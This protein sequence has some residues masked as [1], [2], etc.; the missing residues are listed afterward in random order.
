MLRV[1]WCNGL[2]PE[3]YQYMCVQEIRDF[4]TLVHKCRM[5]DDAGKAKTNHYKAVHDKKGKGHG[6]GKP[7]NKD[8]GKKREVG[9]GSKSSLADVRCF[10][11]G[12]FGH[13]SNDCKKDESCFKCGQAG[14]KSFECKKEVTCYNCGEKGHISAKCTKP[15]KAAGKVFALNAEEV[16]QPDNLIRGMCFINSTPLIA[17]IDTGATHSFISAS[18]VERLNLVVTSLLRGMVI[19]TPAS[20]S[21]TTSLVCARCPVNF[22]N[23]D[24]ELD[25]VCLPLK[26]MDVIFGMD[27]MLTFGVSI[28]CL[29]KSITFSKPVDELGGKF[30]T[31]EQVKKSLDS[32]AC[33]FMM[34]ASLKESSEKEVGDLPVVQEF[35]EVFPDDITELPLEREVEFAID[36]VPGTS[37][38]SIAPYRMSAS[39]LG[40]LKKQL[41]ELLEKQFIHPSVSPWGAPVLLVK[42]K[43]G[44]MRLLWIIGS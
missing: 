2:R 23:V 31:A 1:Q 28:N 10:K 6:F 36:L 41:D 35:P 11:C 7:Y 39:E 27:W 40:E 5:F 19:N 21:V 43:D 3:I 37:P 42:K 30:L 34:F 32:E 12:V 20:G 22:G 13:Y 18:C 25:L 24:F 44:S 17:I 38:I 14:H 26:H 4:D 9:G 33:V 8:K 16:E 15:R 29:T